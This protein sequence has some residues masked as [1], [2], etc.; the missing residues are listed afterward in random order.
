MAKELTAQMAKKLVALRR[1]GKSFEEISDLLN[2]P[3]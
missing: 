2:V 3:I 1:N